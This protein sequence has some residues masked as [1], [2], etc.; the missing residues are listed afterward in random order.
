[1]H[2]DQRMHLKKSRLLGALDRLCEGLE[3]TNTQY[4]LAK[5]RYEGVAEWL[6]EA[7]DPRM[8]DIA[9]FLQG[10][11]ALGTTVK[12]IRQTEYDVDLVAHLPHLG[13]L[14]P[15]E[16]KKAI[17]DRL[18]SNGHYAPLLE[19]KPRCWRLVYANEFHLDITPSI[20]NPA[21]GNGGELVP[22][23]ALKAWKASN[24]KGYKS[25]FA[26]RA[27]LQPRF[28]VL[29][30]ALSMESAR[31]DIEPYPAAK[32]PKGILRRAVQI[33]KRHRDVYFSALN[34]ALAPISVLITT[35]VSQSYE[36]CVRNT[37]YQDELDL[38]YDVLHRMPDFIETRSGPQGPQWFVWNETTQGENFAEKWN[39]AP[40]RAEAF[41]SW[42]HQAMNDLERLKEAEGLDRFGQVLRESFGSG[43]ANAVIK[44]LTEEVSAARGK[45]LLSVD[46]GVGLIIGSGAATRLRHNTFFGAE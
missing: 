45:G 4:V 13:L 11:T 34:P 1:M 42:H 17:G 38:L 24:P 15:A 29:K 23:K 46:A 36:E 3:I 32:G 10:S 39:K 6:A 22:D 31:A 28:Q 30:G 5:Q 12:P 43:P 26:W 44:A 40:E 25:L 16:V 7:E 20:R 14:P 35:L 19:E 41:F 2:I 33:A 27:G 8:R 18:R 9:I 21:C 37:L